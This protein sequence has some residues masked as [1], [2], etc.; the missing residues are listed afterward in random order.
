MSLTMAAMRCS[1]SRLEC[2][3]SSSS[4][5]LRSRLSATSVWPIDQVGQRGAQ[6]VRHVGVEAFELRTPL[7]NLIGHTEVALSRERSVPELEETL[8]SNME[9]LHRMAAIARMH[10]GFPAAE[11]SGGT[12]RVGFSLHSSPAAA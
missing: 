9:E 7:A 6:L 4:A 12:T 10:D 5:T 11:S 2:S 3:V 8:H 1:S